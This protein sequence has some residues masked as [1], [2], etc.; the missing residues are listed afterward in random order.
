MWVGVLGMNNEGIVNSILGRYHKDFR[1]LKSVEWSNGS[2][3]KGKFLVKDT[4]HLIG[5][6]LKHLAITEI[7]MCLNEFFQ[8]YVAKLIEECYIKEWQDLQWPDYWGRKSSEH[9]FVVESHIDFNE[10]IDP[11]KEFPGILVLHDEFKSKR[12]N[13]HL[14]FHFDFGEGAHTG[15]IRLA[16][17]P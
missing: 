16:F 2:K 14:K 12:G 9:L 15:Y 7:Q 10:I 17:V 8:V 3:I 1:Y 11:N 5:K 13:Y 4:A 6:P